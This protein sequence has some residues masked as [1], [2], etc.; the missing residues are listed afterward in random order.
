M[1]SSTVALKLRY[2]ARASVSAAMGSGR[3][4]ASMAACAKPVL[5]RTGERECPTGQPIT[6]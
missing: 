4:T 5:W 1:S 2:E 6:P 3:Y